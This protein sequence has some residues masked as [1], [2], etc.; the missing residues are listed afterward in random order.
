VDA[1]FEYAH[2]RAASERG[3]L[4]QVAALIREVDAYERG[5]RAGRGLDA[6]RTALRPV[7]VQGHV[8]E[9]ASCLMA[10]Q[11]GKGPDKA[12]QLAARLVPMVPASAVK[13]VK[14]AFEIGKTLAL[15]Q[16]RERERERGLSR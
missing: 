14:Q 13:L 16:D 2:Q 12:A 15:G 1:A 6:A 11:I 10:A 9:A 3:A 5:Q 4:K 7:H 8:R